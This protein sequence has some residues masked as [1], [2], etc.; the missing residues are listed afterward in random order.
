MFTGI[1]EGTGRI[2][3]VKK[4]PQGMQIEVETHFDLERSNVGESIAVN[5][6]C[7][8]ITSRLGT[9]FWADVSAETLDKTTLGDLSEGSAVNL[10]R[11]L[12]MGERLG[13][14]LVQGHVDGIGS[15]EAIQ[16]AGEAREI[17]IQS[18][19]KLAC[20]L[21][22]KGS[23]AV[24]GVS[25]TINQ[26]ERETFSVMIIPH[27]QMKTTFHGLKTGNRVNLEVD[28]IGKYVAK[29]THFDSEE[30]QKGTKI[31]QEFLKKHGF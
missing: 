8:T 29:L 21:V 14:H 7:L 24:D 11:P 5:G 23:I 3:S 26:V 22:E 20:Y 31:T 13:G 25:L 12:K 15:V 19:Q 6:C 10:E 17:R 27:T 28:I 2:K 18:P 16:A 4:V 1:I 9:S 30:Y